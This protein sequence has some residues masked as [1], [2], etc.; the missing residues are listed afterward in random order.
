MLLG[1]VVHGKSKSSPYYRGKEVKM[2]DYGGPHSTNFNNHFQPLERLVVKSEG[3]RALGLLV[4][5]LFNASLVFTGILLF[6][7]VVSRS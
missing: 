3:K 5:V 6:P 7:M 2:D 1:R 4:G